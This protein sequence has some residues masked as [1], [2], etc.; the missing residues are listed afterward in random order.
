[1]LSRQMI[2]AFISMLGGLVTMLGVDLDPATK[3]ALVNNLEIVIG[4]IV[5]LYGIVMA[6]LR[7]ITTSP[8]V[9]WFKKEEQ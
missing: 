7:K 3:D 4:G 6:L 9:G 8:L 5:T 1:M 2:V